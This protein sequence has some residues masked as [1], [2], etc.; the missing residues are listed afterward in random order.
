MVVRGD[1]GPLQATRLRTFMKVYPYQPGGVGTSF[2]AFLR[3]E[4]RLG[5]V[6]TPPETVFHDCNG[7]MMNT[8]GRIPASADNSPARSSVRGLVLLAS[9][10]HRR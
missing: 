8:I 6:T 5:P 10:R 3:G 4:A 1:G 7:K 2:A 9:R